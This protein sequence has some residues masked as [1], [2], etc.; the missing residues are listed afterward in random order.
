MTPLII[1]KVSLTRL[2]VTPR[3]INKVSL[4][5]LRNMVEMR[6]RFIVLKSPNHIIDASLQGDAVK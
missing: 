3:K 4:T 6:I 1:N 2:I 5:R